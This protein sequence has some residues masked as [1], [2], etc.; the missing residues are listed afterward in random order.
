MP[1]P[2]VSLSEMEFDLDKALE[3]VPIH[4]EDPPPPPPQ[5]LDRMSAYYADLPA[6]PTPLDTKSVILGEL[7]PVEHKMLEHHTKL[8][9]KPMKRTK[10]SRPP[11]GFPQGLISKS[12]MIP[13]ILLCCLLFVCCLVF[14]TSIYLSFIYSHSLNNFYIM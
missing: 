11:V 6:P 4:V 12:S 3:E 8:R 13:I 5:P 7:P 2:S 9:P 1:L 14:T 10:P